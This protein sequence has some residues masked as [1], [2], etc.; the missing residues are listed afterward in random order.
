MGKKTESFSGGVDDNFFN[1]EIHFQSILDENTCNF[2]QHI[3]RL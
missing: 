2:G 3:D 1:A